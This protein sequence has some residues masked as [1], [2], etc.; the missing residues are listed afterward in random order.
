VEYL[1]SG[2][3]WD[4]YCEGLKQ[5]GKDIFRDLAPKDPIDLAEGHRYLTRAV[6]FGLTHI[7]EAG[8]PRLPYFFPSLCEHLKSGW[9]NP[10]N[11]HSNAYINGNYDYKVSGTRG[12][13][14]YLSFAVY[15]G[16]IGREGGRSTVAYV[17]IDDLE[18]NPDGT[19]EVILSQ[20][21][22]SGNWIPL[23][24]NATTL[25][26]RETF[27]NKLEQTRAALRIE[28]LSDDPP[29][30]LTPDFVVG[31]LRR[32]LRF[33]RGSAKVF[34]DTADAWI[35]QP[36]IVHEGNKEQVGQT[37]G[38][39]DQHYGSGWWICEPDQAIV[40]DVMP[41]KCRYWNF[42]LSDYWGGS[43]DY[44][45]W[46][47]HVNMQSAVYRSDGSLLIIVAHADPGIADAN[48]LDPCG[49]GQGVWTLRWNEAEEDRIPTVRVV[50]AAELASL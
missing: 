7:M 31:A 2:D 40:L 20:K 35:P 19:F 33:M 16:S 3:A 44:R 9:D 27:W 6:R 42:V 25:M 10:D 12:D 29:P 5:A 21:E 18:V 39:P 43:F 17:K 49:H 26:V 13:A 45:Y 41:P 11:H 50:E 4:D 30:T 28:C 8:D 46:K 34:F 38:I 23:N 15:G 24:E 1:A 47:I 14:H 36:N 22:Q 48:W 37:M 32:S